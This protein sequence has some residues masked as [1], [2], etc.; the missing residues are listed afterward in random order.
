MGIDVSGPLVGTGALPPEPLSNLLYAH[1][2]SVRL[3]ITD[4]NVQIM[5]GEFLSEDLDSVARQG[6][7]VVQHI[8]DELEAEGF[9]DLP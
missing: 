5:D 6:G 7:E 3:V 8:W 2:K 9:F 4:G 1:G